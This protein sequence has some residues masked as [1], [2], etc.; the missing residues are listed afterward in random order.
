M[1][2]LKKMSGKKAKVVSFINY[3]GGVAKTTSTYHIG[4]W[5]AGVKEKNVLLIDIDPQTNLTFLCASIEDWEKRKS[6]IGTI[7][8]MY[9]RFL[10]EKPIE[11]ERYVWQSPII[12]ERIP[13]LDLI[14][15][16]IDLI[17]TDIRDSEVAGVYPSMEMLQK[18]AEQFIRDRS[19][20]REVVKELEEKYDYIFIDCP[21]NLYLMTQNALA[22]SN[23]YV[24]TAIP[25]HLSTIGLNILIEKTN[26]LEKFMNRASIL[27]GT[28]NGNNAFA[29][30][31]AALFVRVRIGG[32]MITNAHFDKMEQLRKGPLECFDTHTTELIGYTEAA[33]NSLPVWLHDTDNA[34]RAAEK[35]EYP[36]IAEEFLKRF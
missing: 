11:A 28:R 8:T 10:D 4:C 33:E 18:N 15:C 5:L 9:K 29:Q 34:Y 19:F 6:G 31:G 22:A 32:A 27:A 2:V 24:I 23:W 35:Q 17:G 16:D 7:A 3:K 26:K 36:Q 13:R 25:D 20:L 1:K 21:P 30:F 12:G 14:P